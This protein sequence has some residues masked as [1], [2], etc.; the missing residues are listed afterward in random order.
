M[1]KSQ[2]NILRGQ[3]HH[4]IYQVYPVEPQSHYLR[5][6]ILTLIS[7]E[8][9]KNRPKEQKLETGDDWANKLMNK[10][11]S[12]WND[13]LKEYDKVIDDFLNSLKPK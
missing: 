8:I 10:Y 4:L 7:K 2:T 12:G 9:K 6:K 5:D 13:A 1:S 11:P 3:V